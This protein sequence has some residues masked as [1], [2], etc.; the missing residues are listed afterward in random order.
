M[1]WAVIS[2]TTVLFCSV[3]YQKV[4]DKLG[5]R[6][7]GLSRAWVWEIRINSTVLHNT[8]LHWDLWRSAILTYAFVV[9]TCRT[10]S[11]QQFPVQFLVCPHR[12]EQFLCLWPSL[13]CCKKWIHI[14]NAACTAYVPE[15]RILACNSSYKLQHFDHQNQPLLS[16]LLKLI[17]VWMKLLYLWDCC[18]AC[19]L[20]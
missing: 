15:N 2:Y 20:Q 17:A 4:H 10:V 12:R 7:I 5:K 18:L 14:F 13:H 16:E 19:F 8:W 3:F 11:S 6:F 1:T 9:Q